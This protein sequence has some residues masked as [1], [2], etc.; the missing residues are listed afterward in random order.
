[1]VNEA[2]NGETTILVRIGKSLAFP[3][4]VLL[5]ISA[6]LLKPSPSESFASIAEKLWFPASVP[7]LL[8]KSAPYGFLG[9]HHLHLSGQYDR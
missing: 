8:K 1:M 5:F 3:G 6:M 9:L 7:L 4:Y 2:V